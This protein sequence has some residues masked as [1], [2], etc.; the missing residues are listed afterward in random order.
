MMTNARLWS[1]LN[2]ATQMVKKN[3]KTSTPTGFE[4]GALNVKKKS[5]A[6]WQP[7]PI[8]TIK[9]P[10][11]RPKVS[12]CARHT[13]RGRLGTSGLKTND[14]IAA[15]DLGSCSGTQTC[16]THPPRTVRLTRRMRRLNRKSKTR[17]NLNHLSERAG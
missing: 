3:T 5:F 11:T 10:N 1:L 8:N 4:L 12:L 2:D 14:L 16:P 15:V 6:Q 7:C 9:A 13:P 17:A